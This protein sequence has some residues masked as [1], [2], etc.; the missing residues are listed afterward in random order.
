MLDN[1]SSRFFPETN[2]FDFFQIDI[3]SSDLNEFWIGQK[4][5]RATP[6][7][8]L[9]STGFMGVWAKYHV[10]NQKNKIETQWGIFFPSYRA[11]PADPLATLVRAAHMI[12][13]SLTHP[14]S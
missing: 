14:K 8:F 6:V 13:Y 9:L 4:I 3:T 1:F 10:E 2:F 12:I 7:L 5:W 11:Q